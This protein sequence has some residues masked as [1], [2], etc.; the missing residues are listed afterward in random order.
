M[1]KW[2]ERRLWHYVPILLVC[3][4]MT[5]VG[6][7]LINMYGK[8]AIEHGLGFA[9]VIGGVMGVLFWLTQCH[10][11]TI[12]VDDNHA[13]ALVKKES[14]DVIWPG[15]E[16]MRLIPWPFRGCYETKRY[17][18]RFFFSS[19]LC[20][21]TTNPQVILLSVRMI[22]ELQ[23]HHHMPDWFLRYLADPEPGTVFK[24]EAFEIF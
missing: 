23:E 15:L 16:R 18:T 10:E 20:P 19:K 14:G 12:K 9:M 6:I 11:Y 24:R 5:M 1:K 17:C 21:I 8:P 3:S 7:F 13:L 4:L 2:C 22:V